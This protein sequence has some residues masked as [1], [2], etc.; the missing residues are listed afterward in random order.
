MTDTSPC[1]LRLHL[2][3]AALVANWQ[4]LDALS[5][6]AAACGA[7]VKANAYGLGVKDVVARL[8]NAGCRDFFV[9][10]WPEAAEIENLTAGCSVT[11]LNGVLDHDMAIAIQLAA[12]PMLNS[13]QQIARWRSTGRACDVMVNT[14]MNRLGVDVAD[15]VTIDWSGL[16]IDVL[17]SHL[18][19]ADEDSAQ[20]NE[21]LQLF[22]QISGRVPHRRRSLANSAAI[23]LGRQYAFDLTRPGLAL[24][25]GVPRA[26][27]A[28]SIRP[29]AS[30]NSAI[31]QRRNLKRG[32]RVG[33]N[34]TFTASENT[35]AAIISIGYADGYLRGFS[36]CG[37]FF[38]GGAALP[39]IGRVSMDLVV[40]D[41]S[42]AP[43]LGEGDHVTLMLDLPDMSRLSGLSQYE[44]LTGL[45]NRFDRVWRD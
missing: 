4:A 17:S 21:Q 1:S 42:K 16:Q 12:K 37:T 20:N 28:P 15:L 19:S 40:L 36:N 13:P 34:A 43:R 33:Y 6:P 45:G 31:I 3:G 27:L 32:D 26:E 25:G 10:T 7:A 23:G 11:V 39:V 38:S 30:I 2:D 24:Y 18:A 8:R 14:G 29:I 9:A 41:I 5:G 44:L 22:A 35:P